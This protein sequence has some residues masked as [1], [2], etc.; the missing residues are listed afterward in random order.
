MIELLIS[1]NPNVLEI[2]GCKDE[3][4]LILKPAGKLLRDN[5]DLFLSQRVVYTFGSYAN[6]Q[7][8]RLQNALARDNYPQ[9]EKEQ[10]ILKSIEGQKYHLQTNYATFEDKNMKLYIDKSNKTNFETEIFMDI[11]LKHYPLRD[12][13][14]MYSDMAN[15]I[16]NYDSL[17]HRN[18]KKDQLHLDKH[19]MH[20]IRLL[21][22]GAE[23][24]EGKGVITHREQDRDLLMSI[25]NGDL[26][27]EVDGNK[28]YSEVF[29][30]VTDLEKKFNY[31]KE[32]T[33]LPEKPDY[34]NIN[35]L[36]M[37]INRSVVK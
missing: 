11:D 24:L 30:I 32:N 9:S 17:N 8:R 29:A 10:H 31:A 25:R 33:V 16:K 27:R 28:D 1:N 13:K 6:S 20:L 12:F 15:V 36:V 21:I 3:H 4:Y 2:M 7:L 34:N 5:I 19:A 35:E 22:T 26:V 18:S 14:G 23:V 37:E